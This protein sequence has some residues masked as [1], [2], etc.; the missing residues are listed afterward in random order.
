MSDRE[1]SG[2]S[3]LIIDSIVM[4]I[5]HNWSMRSPGCTF[6]LIGFSMHPIRRNDRNK[7]NEQRSSGLLLLTPAKVY[8]KVDRKIL[9]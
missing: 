8:T 1:L 4:L 6:F 5:V 3:N 7:T 2:I 9:S